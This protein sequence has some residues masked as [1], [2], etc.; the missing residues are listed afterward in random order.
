[1]QSLASYKQRVELLYHGLDFA[2]LPRAIETSRPPRDGSDVND[3]VQLL[4]VGRCVEKK[5]F[6]DL[7]RALAL[8]P[9]DLHWRLLQIGG[10]PLRPN[11][12]VLAK[13]LGIEERC[14]FQGARPQE[15]VFAAYRGADLFA[16]TARIAED[17]DRDGLPNVLMEAQSQGL[18][19]LATRVG[20][21][22]ELIEEGATGLLA[23]SGDIKAMARGLERLMR[24]PVLRFRLGTAGQQKV[25]EDFSFSA[26]IERL[27]AHLRHLA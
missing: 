26:G 13:E 27:Y 2:H 6:D 14:R 20:A 23:E 4:S 18:A 25:R 11:L 15:D 17:G 24:D 8:L 21:I 22:E 7:L 1:L 5:G 12:M 10:G 3:P 19:C 16:L 9:K